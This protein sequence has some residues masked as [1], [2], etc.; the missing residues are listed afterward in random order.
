[1]ARFDIEEFV[2][3]QPIGRTQLAVLLVCGLV[4]FI[5]GFDIFM[6][7]KI[8]PAIAADFGEAPEAMGFLF[9]CQQI[10][11]AAGAFIVSPLADRFGRRRML[12]WACAL[13]GLIT[14]FSVYAQTLTQLAILRGIAGL[15]MAAGLP[16]A[17]ALISEMTPRR[18]RSMFIAIALAGY[19]T[20]SAAS[21]AVAAWLL[22]GYGWES[23][24]VI[25]G[26]VPLVCIP[27]LLFFV[28]ESLKYVAERDPAD[29]RIAAT[30]ARM[31]GA[32]NLTGAEEFVLGAGSARPQKARLLD[33]FLDGRA[34][35][36]A[37]IWAAC[38]LSMTNIALLASW[39]PTF[40]QE[41]KGIPIQRFAISAMI[42]YLGGLA[43]MLSIGWLMD[44]FNPTRLI[45]L[46]YLGLAGA[47]VAMAWVPF[48]AALFVG[49]LL[50]WNFVQT[51]GQGG[52][53]TLITQVYPPRMRSTALGWAGG[54]G[55]VG[56]VIAPLFGAYAIEQQFSLELT[57]GLVAIGPLTV[58][59]LVFLLGFT[60]VAQRREESSGRPVPA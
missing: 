13:F 35:M 14:L 27:L 33:I 39:L 30:V 12:I 34:W 29:P 49:V 58:A 10:G 1:M 21:G 32:A 16:M 6:V 60:A 20:G 28:P 17:L 8:A 40:F 52:L 22:D 24:F 57:L 43:G 44:R 47:L 3:R 37:L 26:I 15:F 53:N 36:T 38:I 4:C 54:A 9:V 41:M 50:F 18:R 25:G 19:S 7:G 59:V 5:D 11:L 45:S 31:D 46:Y 23:G 2:D 42:A 51:G 55:R 56:G 48:E